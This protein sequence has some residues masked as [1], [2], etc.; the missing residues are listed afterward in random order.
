MASPDQQ[1]RGKDVFESVGAF[2]AQSRLTS[3]RGV[4]FRCQFELFD[5]RV[6]CELAGETAGVR[7]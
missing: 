1:R 2:R 4:F 3:S 7:I 6:V 5:L